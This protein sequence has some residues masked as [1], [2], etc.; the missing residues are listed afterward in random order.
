MRIENL[1]SGGCSIDEEEQKAIQP[2]INKVCDSVSE[3]I[4]A[5]RDIRKDTGMSKETTI[6]LI[7]HDV[8]WL[9]QEITCDIEC[10][11]LLDDYA[12]DGDGN[13]KKYRECMDYYNQLNDNHKSYSK[14]VFKKEE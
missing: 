8:E 9:I 4:D 14:K 2:A 13:G 3:L 1:I 10:E 7:M 11:D 5:V 12:A 6:A